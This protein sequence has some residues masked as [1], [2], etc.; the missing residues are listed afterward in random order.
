MKPFDD[1]LPAESETRHRELLTMLQRA[2]LKP[3]ALTAD[4]H[5]QAI[6]R[7]RDRLLTA[8]QQADEDIPAPQAGVA[9]SAPIPA[10]AMP[11]RRRRIINLLNSLAAVL[12]VGAIVGASLLLFT[13]HAASPGGAPASTPS[14]IAIFVDL[15]IVASS[16]ENGL[17]MTLAM[18]PGP[19]FLSE[20]LAV[21]ISLTNHSSKTYLVGIPFVSS[22]CGY[23]TGLS[24][25]GGEKPYFDI[26]I[27]IDHS[28]PAGSGGVTLQP[29]K[30]LTA[31]VYFPLMVSGH[32]SLSATT[33]FFDTSNNPQSPFRRPASNPLFKSWPTARF[34]VSAK[35]PADRALTFKR[36][37]I[38]VTVSL[39]PQ[40]QS[41]LIYL[42]GVFCQ[43]SN[44]DG[45]STGTGNFG[46]YP[47]SGN[48]VTQP[49]CPGIHVQWR[50]ALGLPGYGIAEGRVTS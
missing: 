5:D 9:Y 35:I 28:C 15:P 50:F 40:A 44:N 46:W 30:T 26:P 36:Q 34:D 47:I 45:G 33:E 12:V 1:L 49:A 37:G 10:T 22:A 3:A 38:H 17:E 6:T 21:V 41:P 20:L 32:V 39:P 13:R 4:E 48:Q 29:G 14:S 19:Y 31:L 2:Y 42:Y 23:A 11:R 24:L 18:T 43:D 16:S 8:D 25:S 7:V 27:S